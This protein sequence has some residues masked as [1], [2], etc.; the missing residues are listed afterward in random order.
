MPGVSLFDVSCPWPST[1]ALGQ[2][3]LPF[4]HFQRR[5]LRAAEA[6]HVMSIFANDSVPCQEHGELHHLLRWTEVTAR[7]G[8]VRNVLGEVGRKTGEPGKALATDAL[9][10]SFIL[11]RY[12]LVKHFYPP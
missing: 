11:T 10:W 5:V 4:H 3:R 6:D 8:H 7:Y 9:Y 1:H 2:R 12:R